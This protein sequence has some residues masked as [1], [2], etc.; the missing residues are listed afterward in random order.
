MD[1][2]PFVFRFGEFE[3]REREF[4]LIKAGDAVSI[5]PK[6]FRVLLFLLRSPGRLIRKDEILNA[7]WDDCSVS[8]NS[9]TRSIATLRRLL[10]DDPR[11]PRYIETLATV[12]YRFVCKVEVSEIAEEDIVNK[13]LE[14]DRN[15]RY[16]QASEIRTDLQPLKLDTDSGRSAGLATTQAGTVPLAADSVQTSPA[17]VAAR[18]KTWVGVGV[19]IVLLA[20]GTG[21]LRLRQR[22]G[23]SSVE[24]LAVLPF[25][26]TPGQDMDEYLVDGITEGMINDLSQVSALRVMARTTVFRFKGK[27]SDPH[28]VGATLKVGCRRYRPH[29]SARR[30]PDDSSRACQS[31][32]W[33]ADLGT[34]VY[35]QD[36]GCFLLAGRYW[37]RDCIKVALASERRG[38]TADDGAWNSQGL[39]RLNTTIH[40]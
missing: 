16:Q 36:E 12:G 17:S 13:W 25:T 31:F 5:E 9:L 32:G 38:E 27:E 37:A 8:D 28:P 3:V 35:A 11:N 21:A 1:H 15:L 22:S 39:E 30:R 23:H 6:A 18:W 33:H 10:G 40:A 4:L 34:A 14:K 26:A 20:V 24:S 2:K 7:V 29:R 19:L